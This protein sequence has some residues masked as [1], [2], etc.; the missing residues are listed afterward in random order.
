MLSP[1]VLRGRAP[2]VEDIFGTDVIG[3]PEEP[4]LDRGL[5]DRVSV[6]TECGVPYGVDLRDLLVA[7]ALHTPEV[8]E[9]DGAVVVEQVIAG[10][11]VGV[12]Q[13]VAV[14][15]SPAEAVDRLAPLIAQGL[16]GNQRFGPTPT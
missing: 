3:G 2:V 7:E 9:T 15:S 12:D 5:P 4:T 13:A 1:T 16:I 6:A 11:R 8:E 10:V 14:Q